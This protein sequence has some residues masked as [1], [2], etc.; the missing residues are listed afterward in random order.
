MQKQLYLDIDRNSNVIRLTR[1][2]FVP[3]RGSNEPLVEIR[4][5]LFFRVR[6]QLRQ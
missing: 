6:I 2:L 5:F 3:T 4:L 1:Q